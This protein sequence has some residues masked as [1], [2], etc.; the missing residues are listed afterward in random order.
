[1]SIRRRLVLLLLVATIALLGVAGAALYQLQRNAGMT[2][3]LTEQTVPAFLAAADIGSRLKSLQIAVI[4]AVNEPDDALV[5]QFKERIAEDKRDLHQQ[6]RN[7]IDTA[8]SE[9]QQGL[10]KQALASLEGYY[11]IVDQVTD[12]RLQGQQLIAQAAL[13]GTAG[14]QLA[15][16][17]QVLGTLLVEK[18]RAKEDALAAIDAARQQAMWAVA[19]TLLLTLLLLAGSGYRLYRRIVPPLRAMEMAMARISRDLD[20][21]LRVPAGNDDEVGQ[22]IRAFNTLIDVLQGSLADMADVIRNNE[23]VAAEMQRSAGTLV[24]IASGGS[25]SSRDIQSAVKEVQAQIVR[26]DA[27]TRQ[28]GSA[29]EVSGRQ[30]TENGR[31]IREAAERINALAS[32]V[33]SAA[34]R[35]FALATASGRIALQL[36]EIREIADQTNLLALNAAIEA[37]RAGESG[38]GFAVVADEVRKLAER[39]AAATLSI[40]VQVRDIDATSGESTQLMQQVVEEITHNIALTSSAGGAM[41]DIE[42]SARQV[43][44]TVEQIGRQVAVGHASSTQIVAQVDTIDGLMRTAQSAADK[45]RDCADSVRAISARMSEIVCRFRIA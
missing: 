23:V 18:Q 22:S 25:A 21:T 10:I 29:T 2:R 16:L 7:Q 44:A 20:F 27:D 19:A 28:A 11:E 39:V 8:T 45:A 1:M 17:E 38:R 35:V 9:A 6:V 33:E 13:A 15:E 32:G 30:A 26:I 40:S 41:S 5:A 12:L 37:A 36:K 3:V 34:Q 14:P 42:S 4:S 24:Q 43:V 31:I